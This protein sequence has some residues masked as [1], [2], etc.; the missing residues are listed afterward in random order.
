MKSH[1][2]GGGSRILRHTASTVRTMFVAQLWLNVGWRLQ[3]SIHGES[4]SRAVN[5]L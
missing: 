1:I 3:E 5:M 4:T 2:G